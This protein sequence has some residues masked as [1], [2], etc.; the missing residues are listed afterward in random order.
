MFILWNCVF[1]NSKGW[2]SCTFDT[3]FMYVKLILNILLLLLLNLHVWIVVIWN[4]V[5]FCLNWCKV[6]LWL[7]LLM[8]SWLNDVIVVVRCCCCWFMPCVFTVMEY[9]CKLSC[10]EFLWKMDILM[11]CVGMVFDFKFDMIWLLFYVHKHMNKLWEQ[12]WD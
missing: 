10:W 3:M 5:D 1:V 8:N 12:I 7:K 9:W 2:I 11:N 4:F 6:I